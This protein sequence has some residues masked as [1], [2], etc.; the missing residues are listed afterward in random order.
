MS[1]E[2]SKYHKKEKVLNIAKTEHQKL[3]VHLSAKM[4]SITNKQ[5]LHS[6][7]KFPHKWWKRK[8]PSPWE[9]LWQSGR[10][11]RVR[12]ESPKWCCIKQC[13]TFYKVWTGCGKIKSNETS[14]RVPHNINW[15]TDN[16][17]MNYKLS[18]RDTLY[19][20]HGENIWS[21]AWASVYSHVLKASPRR[22]G[23]PSSPWE[24]VAPCRLG[25]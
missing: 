17:E 7:S 24:T 21:Y 9:N 12:K 5:H 18:L 22:P 11:S 15:F 13:D 6:F 10:C 16:L 2:I 25:V 20:S 8:C 19:K 3:L 14:K 1:Y 23:V 4:F